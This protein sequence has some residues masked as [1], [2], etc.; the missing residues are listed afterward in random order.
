MLLLNPVPIA[1]RF[2]RIWMTESSEHVRH[3][4]LGSDRRNC[5]GYAIR[6]LYL[7][8]QSADGKFYDLVRHTADQDQTAT[9]CSSIDPWHEAADIGE[10][11]ATRLDSISSTPAA[12]PAVCRR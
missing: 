4:R 7:G 3:T 8:T 5:V 9:V 6:E 11:R 2:L 10:E 1:V 12:T